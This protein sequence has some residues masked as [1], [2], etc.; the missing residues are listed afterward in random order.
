MDVAAVVAADVVDD[1]PTDW[2]WVSLPHA[3]EI[4]TAPTAIGANQR[5]DFMRL[6]KTISGNNPGNLTWNVP[7]RME[8]AMCRAAWCQLQDNV[9]LA[10]LPAQPSPAGALS[11]AI[12]AAP[13]LAPW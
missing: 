2:G 6:L 12:M 8:A 1:E 5:V 13:A 4:K 10:Q 9:Q 3:P 7:V 11:R